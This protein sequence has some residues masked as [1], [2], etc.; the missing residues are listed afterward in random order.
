MQ[1]RIKVATK[2]TA[3]LFLLLSAASILVSGVANALSYAALPLG[4]RVKDSDLV[5]LGQLINVKPKYYS[6][7]SDLGSKPERGL[8]ESTYI[9]DIGQIRI[10]RILKGAGHKGQIGFAF[11]HIKDEPISFTE[12]QRG[13][14]ILHKGWGGFFNV[15]HPDN[16]LE[17]GSLPT[18]QE[19]VNAADEYFSTGLIT[20]VMKAM[21]W[22]TLL[23]TPWVLILVVALRQYRRYHHWTNAFQVLGPGMVL[24]SVCLTPVF[25]SLM[26]YRATGMVP[27]I[28]LATFCIGYLVATRQESRWTG[29]NE[30]VE[31]THPADWGR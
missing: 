13:I 26:V 27:T 16:F 17:H 30:E 12:G 21:I 15:Q 3:V 2:Y 28:A 22:E 4:E 10:D 25:P 11:R 24:L 19:A 7:T 9:Y 5:V 8:G 14:W 23:M 31:A 6:I 29:A 20:K 18:I 1:T